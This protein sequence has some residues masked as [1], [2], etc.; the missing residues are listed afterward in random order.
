MFSSLGSIVAFVKSLPPWMLLGAG[1]LTGWIRSFWAFLYGHTVGYVS[2]K[3]KVEIVVEET[4]H[5]EVYLWI[6][7]WMEDL[8]KKKKINSVR[9]SR[10]DSEDSSDNYRLVAGYGTYYSW[11]KKRLLVFESYKKEIQG[12]RG[13]GILRTVR[14]SVWGTRDRMKLLE[15]IKAAKHHYE[16]VNPERVSY[17][18]FEDGYWESKLMKSRPVE[19]LYLPDDQLEDI[20]SDFE[21]FFRNKPNYEVLGIPW[22][23]GYLLYGPPGT[24]KTTG[25]HVLGS[26]FKLPIYYVSLNGSTSAA[27]LRRQMST[28][29]EP[30]IVLL[31]DVDSINAAQKRKTEDGKE[32][33]EGTLQTRDL[34]NT[35]D[36]LLA[37]EG[38]ILIMTSNH[39]EKLDEALIRAGR[40]DR[41]FYFDYAKESELKKFHAKAAEFFPIP[42]YEAFRSQLPTN[43]TIA[44]AQN[45]VFKSQVDNRRER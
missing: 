27:S 35:I 17:F 13:E 5:R 14:V 45:I 19:T 31:E 32:K 2:K 9:V 24:G 25:V 28:V 43:C 29:V 10:N 44:D 30:C 12:N 21:A 37:T 3:F 36:G 33:T 4:D 6:S 42:D 23:K 7:M 1:F 38:R 16:L 20:M 18:V 22:R 39:P 34:L 41:R 26:H 11:W 15:V 8:L 40:V